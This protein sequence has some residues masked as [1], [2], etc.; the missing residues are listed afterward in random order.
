MNNLEKIKLLPLILEAS[1]LT[2]D[3]EVE[4]KVGSKLFKLAKSNAAKINVYRILYKSGQNK[5]RGYIIEPKILKKKMPCI[6]WC[7]N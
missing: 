6:I 7:G 5:I 1:T 3:P 4:Q 2:L